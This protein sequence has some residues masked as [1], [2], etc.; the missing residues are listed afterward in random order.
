MP[1]YAP[2]STNSTVHIYNFFKATPFSDKASNSASFRVLEL[3]KVK[4]QMKMKNQ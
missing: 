4:G 1:K 2:I 3:K